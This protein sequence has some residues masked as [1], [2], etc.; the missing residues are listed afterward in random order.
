MNKKKSLNGDPSGSGRPVSRKKMHADHAH[1]TGSVGVDQPAYRKKARADHRLTKSETLP[2]LRSNGVEQPASH[3]NAR[4]APQRT[5]TVEGTCKLRPLNVEPACNPRIVRADPQRRNNFEGGSA[6]ASGDCRKH[7]GLSSPSGEIASCD[8]L[9]DMHHATMSIP[10]PLGGLALI[11]SLGSFNSADCP[12]EPPL[13][14]LEVPHVMSA[15]CG[16]DRAHV[17]SSD[18]DDDGGCR[19]TRRRRRMHEGSQCTDALTA[20]TPP[21]GPKAEENVPPAPLDCPDSQALSPEVPHDDVGGINF[22]TATHDVSAMRPR[23]RLSPP[24][25]KAS[26]GDGTATVEGHLISPGASTTPAVHTSSCGRPLQDSLPPAGTA[27]CGLHTDPAVMNRTLSDLRKLLGIGCTMPLPAEA[28]ARSLLVRTPQ[29][30]LV[31][32]G[33]LFHMVLPSGGWTFAMRDEVV[34]PLSRAIDELRATVPACP[35]DGSPGVARGGSP[36]APTSPSLCAQVDHIAPSELLPAR[37][38][39][40]P[41]TRAPPPPGVTLQ[42]VHTTSVK[43]SEGATP[44]LDAVGDLRPTVCAA[45][46]RTSRPVLSHACE[47]ALTEETRTHTQPLGQAAARSAQPSTAPTSSN[48]SLKEAAPTRS[49]PAGTAPAAVDPVLPG[50]SVIP[51]CERRTSKRLSQDVG[52]EHP[53]V[54]LTTH[55]GVRLHA[56]LRNDCVEGTE[57]RP[58]SILSRLGEVPP[59]SLWPL[60]LASLR[61]IELAVCDLLCIVPPG[62]RLDWEGEIRMLTH[63]TGQDAIGPKVTL[64]K[65]LRAAKLRTTLTHPRKARYDLAENLLL[66]LYTSNPIPFPLDGR[67]I[68]Y[69]LNAG[70]TVFTWWPIPAD[71]L[72]QYKDGGGYCLGPDTRRLPLPPPPADA[73][74]RRAFVAL[75]DANDLNCDLAPLAAFCAACPPNVPTESVRVTSHFLGLCRLVRRRRL[76]KNSHGS[77]TICTPPG[78]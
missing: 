15:V 78:C 58:E 23:H 73:V 36:R 61:C 45:P 46:V 1:M 44:P 21:A 33:G 25:G 26:D 6:G 24:R 38:R 14:P 16:D 12:S 59:P 53:R 48:G 42:E 43:P 11:R 5:D 62:A 49:S 50:S 28:E 2:T 20:N 57:S 29:A 7:S 64:A 22:P 31:A 72:R 63:L 47:G 3:E 30:R 40:G 37:Q 27:A 66:V 65:A 4:A 41:R 10:I 51:S 52:G 60:S 35:L 74:F 32:I 76:P 13:P 9:T 69:R 18:D 17:S 75:E 39:E 70:L 54:V 34:A 67:D 56:H 71:G 77:S 8:P 55:G 68:Q 19:R